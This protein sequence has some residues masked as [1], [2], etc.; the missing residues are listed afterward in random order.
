MAKKVYIV[1][2]WKMYK[3]S[4]EATDYI[5]MLA[6]KIEKSEANVF[7]A[8]PY[9]SIASSVHFAKDTKISIGAQNMN[10]AR[11]GAFTGEIAALMLKE[12]GASFVILGHSER[13][14]IFQESEEL[15]QR[16]VLRAFQDELVP[17][18]CVGETLKEHKAKKRDE[19]LKRQ[20]TTALEGI[21]VDEVVSLILAYEPVW[22]IGTGESA[23]PKQAEEAHAVCREVLEQLFGKKIAKGIPILYGGSVKPENVGEL[24]SEKNIDGVLVGGASLD[25]DKFAQIVAG[26][27]NLRKK[28]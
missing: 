1:G 2:N 13:R 5:E 21:P 19:V 9:T 7:L 17:I 20:I 11:E 22:A 6:P 15:I 23:A 10:D 12:A 14:T 28:S 24:V 8:V 26:A 4:R 3:T 27:T 18:L 16:K 25:P